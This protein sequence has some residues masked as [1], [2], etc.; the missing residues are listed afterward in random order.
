[1]PEQQVLDRTAIYQYRRQPGPAPRA[2]RRHDAC[3][4]RNWPL[5]TSSKVTGCSVIYTRAP[6]STGVAGR[7]PRPG[8]ARGSP[9]AD[10]SGALWP[11]LSAL[12]RISALICEQPSTPA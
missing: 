9:S 5:V 10:R 8:N 3:G 1:M 12:T 6:G 7:S 2:G 4:M 11:P